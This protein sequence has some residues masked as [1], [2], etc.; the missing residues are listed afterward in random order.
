MN[1][2]YVVKPRRR[3]STISLHLNRAQGEVVEL[4]LTNSAT[5]FFATIND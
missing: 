1:K 2:Q 3:G 4:H 5:F